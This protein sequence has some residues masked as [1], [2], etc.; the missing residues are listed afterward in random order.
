MAGRD[1]VVRT[2]FVSDWA[3]GDVCSWVAAWGLSQEGVR[4]LRADG[5]DGE[6]LK[7]HFWAACRGEAVVLK[8]GDGA[9]S[10]GDVRRLR[11]ACGYLRD[12]SW[13]QAVWV[14]RTML[15]GLRVL[16]QCPGRMCVRTRRARRCS[17]ASEST[18]STSAILASVTLCCSGPARGNGPPI[19]SS[20]QRYL[21]CTEP[22]I[23]H[24]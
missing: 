8:Q 14:S 24:N 1:I 22:S 20:Q 13:V 3:V 16:Q 17:R 2:A 18:Q 21:S 5:V 15:A 7:R 19:G 23:S 12:A 6:Q 10:E 4:G 9:L 11:Q